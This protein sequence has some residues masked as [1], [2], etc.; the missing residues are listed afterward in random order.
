MKTFLQKQILL[1]GLN[2]FIISE[3]LNLTKHAFIA[4]RL[5][6]EQNKSLLLSVTETS[7]EK[8]V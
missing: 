8:G 3:L 2:F 5:M 4:K 7:A 6:C 1:N